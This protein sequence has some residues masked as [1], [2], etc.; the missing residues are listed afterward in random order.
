MHYFQPYNSIGHYGAYAG[1]GAAMIPYG[2]ADTDPMVVEGE[3]QVTVGQLAQAA[4][5]PVADALAGGRGKGFQAAAS[6]VRTGAAVGG[7]LASSAVAGSTVVGVPVGLGLAAAA[8]VVAFVAHM[9]KGRMTRAQAKKLA[10]KL[11]LKH[12]TEVL[13][14]T[15]RV[16][17]A[18]PAKRKKMRSHLRA[19]IKRVKKVKSKRGVGKVFARIGNPGS[20][21][22]NTNREKLKL[23]VVN[24]VI[25]IDRA[26]ARGMAEHEGPPP[27]ALPWEGLGLEG[28]IA[29]VLPWLVGGA[30]FFIVLAA[31]R[32]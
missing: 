29:G 2:E 3:Q 13:G 11:K 32:K 22:R 9:R 15:R 7:L 20:L 24:A 28:G 10:K 17:Q 18:S 31:V 26:A 19:Q 8:G 4:S 14:W 5:G 27:K 16:L 1:L 25:D 12:A 21:F 30:L 6:G 23:L